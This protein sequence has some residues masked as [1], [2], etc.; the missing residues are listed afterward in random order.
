MPVTPHTPSHQNTTFSSSPA[1]DDLTPSSP[2]P[3]VQKRAASLSP[4]KPTEPYFCHASS[5]L[6]RS[7]RT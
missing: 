5:V 6:I 4:Q 7:N 2:P 1:T 3:M